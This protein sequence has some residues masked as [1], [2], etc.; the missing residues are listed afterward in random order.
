LDVFPSDAR[1]QPLLDI[2]I[3]VVPQ[4]A[5]A[6]QNSVCAE[7]N[8]GGAE[9][10]KTGVGNAAIGAITRKAIVLTGRKEMVGTR[11]LE[12]LTSTVSKSWYSVTKQLTGHPGLPNSLRIQLSPP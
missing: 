3:H 9:K 6:A 5:L 4:Q 2:Y 11:R 1:R 10:L 7:G 8:N 12:L